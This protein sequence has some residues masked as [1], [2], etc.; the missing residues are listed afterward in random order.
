MYLVPVRFRPRA[1]NFF[2]VF[3]GGE[4]LAKFSLFLLASR[5]AA[6]AAFILRS[7]RRSQIFH[8]SSEVM[9][10]NTRIHAISFPIP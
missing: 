8:G 5:S 10:P 3:L 9:F 7:S 6:C 4:G 1:D 2:G